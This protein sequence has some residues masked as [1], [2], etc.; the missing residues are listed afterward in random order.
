MVAPADPRVNFMDHRSTYKGERKPEGQGKKRQQR[1]ESRGAYK[2]DGAFV[3]IKVSSSRSEPI[4]L[5]Q[6][7]G[8]NATTDPIV[9][10]QPRQGPGATTATKSMPK[11]PKAQPKAQA[12][13]P[14]LLANLAQPVE[15]QEPSD[16]KEV[17]KRKARRPSPPPR[18]VALKPKERPCKRWADW[19][20]SGSDDE[21]CKQLGLTLV[22]DDGGDVGDGGLVISA[23]DPNTQSQPVASL[24]VLSKAR[25]RVVTRGIT[26]L[27]DHDKALKNLLC[28]GN[29]GTTGGP[30]HIVVFTSEPG[31]FQDPITHCIDVGASATGPWTPN[32]ARKEL[33]EVG[34][35][36]VV[37][38]IRYNDHNDS[39]LLD[40]VM[41]H[42]ELAGIP[43]LLVDG[44]QTNRRQEASIPIHPVYGIGDISF[45]GNDQGLLD[46]FEGW[47]TNSYP[48]MSP[49]S[50]DDVF[51]QDFVVWLKRVAEHQVATALVS[52]A[53]YPSIEEFDDGTFDQVESPQDFALMD[54]SEEAITEETQLD[55]VDLPGLPLEESER[56]KK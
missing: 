13:E 11:P 16:W 21:I 55:E 41:S 56:R 27:R 40:E 19:S 18:P 36:L 7:L 9:L 46:D 53:A 5:K 38:A 24:A 22:K 25:K 43:Y 2:G 12:V 34:P 37:V 54:P 31:T 50:F 20:D 14:E 47:C 45:Y 1:E 10:R 23:E 42:C 44:A 49:L 52:H 35:S 32:G 8:V 30:K 39:D 17:R 51:A 33:Q 4:V 6:G 26:Q 15:A 3:G 48:Y 28:V 29:L